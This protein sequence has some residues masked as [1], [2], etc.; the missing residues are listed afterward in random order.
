MP[1]LRR[2]LISICP[3]AKKGKSRL[4]RISKKKKRGRIFHLAI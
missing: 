4:R 2:G 3:A 1:T